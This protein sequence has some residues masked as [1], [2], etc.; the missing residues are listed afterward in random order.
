MLGN[1]SGTALGNPDGLGKRT[2]RGR[3]VAVET[4]ELRGQ[5]GVDRL[6]INEWLE[7]SNTGIRN[8]LSSGAYSRLH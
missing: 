8:H 5:M 7:Q 6:T 1:P 2:W 4:F 3:L